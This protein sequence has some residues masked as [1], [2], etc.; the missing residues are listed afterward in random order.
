MFSISLKPRIFL[1]V[2]S[3]LIGSTTF[4][5]V[6]VAAIQE[7]AEQ[8]FDD[9]KFDYCVYPTVDPKNHDLLIHFHGLAGSA[10]SWQNEERNADTR[11]EIEALGKSVP[12]VVSI[13]FG[14]LWLLTDIKDHGDKYNL[15][16]NK[17]LPFLEGKAGFKKDGRLLL[18]GESMG[19]FNA[20]QLYLKDPQ[21][22]SRY[23]ILCPA[24][25]QLNPWSSD[26]DVANFI[27][28][29]GASSFRV[30][31][32]MQVA[33]YNFSNMDEWNTNNPLYLAKNHTSGLPPIYLSGDEHD[34]YGFYE[35]DKILYDLL[36]TR[37][38]EHKWNTIDGRHCQIDPKGVA[39]FL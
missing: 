32:Y 19:G 4:A 37:A 17:I 25:S 1:F 20:L 11:R 39:Q 12:T 34:Q 3:C 6:N 23:M 18:M 16:K 27:D 13:S 10:L 14:D 22:F 29:T 31:F 24:L 8:T 38:T 7:C 35:G 15:F 5:Q 9:Q 33:K 30:E 28:R 21:I 2:V 36:T 26:E